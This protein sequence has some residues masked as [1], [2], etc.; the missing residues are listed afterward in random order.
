MWSRY[1]AGKSAELTDMMTVSLLCHE[2]G[3]T[4]DEYHDQPI[5]FIMTLARMIAHKR[6]KQNKQ[7]KFK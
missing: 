2:M 3:W 7:P 6:E 5:E 1:F 4:W